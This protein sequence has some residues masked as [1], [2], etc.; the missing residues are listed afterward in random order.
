M[1][2]KL[3]EGK[4]EESFQGLYYI[5]YAGRDIAPKAAALTVI[6]S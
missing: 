6:D 5:F 1:Q 4:K 3:N 2:I